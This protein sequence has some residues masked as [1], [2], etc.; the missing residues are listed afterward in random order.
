[1]QVMQ[2]TDCER[3]MYLWKLFYCDVDLENH[4]RQVWCFEWLRLFIILWWYCIL[5]CVV[6]NINRLFL[7]E[8]RTPAFF[9]VV[10]YRYVINVLQKLC[11]FDFR[12]QPKQ[13]LIVS[14]AAPSPEPATGEG[15]SRKGSSRG[16]KRYRETKIMSLSSPWPS[17]TCLLPHQ[18]S[19]TYD[20]DLIQSCLPQKNCLFLNIM[21]WMLSAWWWLIWKQCV[22]IQQISGLTNWC[23]IL[24]RTQILFTL[25]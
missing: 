14:P 21:E 6:R 17:V 24:I 4:K 13:S 9:A 18:S 10:I 19:V 2:K 1:M 25:H 20:N 5:Y 8:K 23:V 15:R 3:Q 11:G 16:R 7:K 12:R 22:Y